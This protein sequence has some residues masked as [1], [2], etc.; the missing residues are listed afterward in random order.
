MFSFLFLHCKYSQIK[1]LNYIFIERKLVNRW[2]KN[3]I[4]SFCIIF[5]LVFLAAACGPGSKEPVPG[6]ADK[7]STE[8]PQGL[9][10]SYNGKDINVSLE[11]IMQLNEVTREITAVPKDDEEMKPRNVKGIL[12]EDV[13]QSYL[14]ISQ[15]DAGSIRLEAGDGYAIEVASDILKT[16][17]IIIAYEIDGKPLEDWEK[18]L[19]S[20]IPDVFEMYWV[21]NLI[22][23]EITDKREQNQVKRIIFLET[24]I[25]EVENID[26]AY[27]DENSKA[28]KISD[29][30]FNFSETEFQ[31]YVFIMST[32]GLEKIEKAEIFLDA[33]IK[34]TGQYAPMFLSE[35]LPKGMW[36]KD[37]LYFIY[38]S[39]V[40]FSE[41]SGFKVFDKVNTNGSQSIILKDVFRSCGI[42]ASE[43]YLFKSLDGYT[44]EIESGSID[45][46]FIYI[47]DNGLAAVYFEGLAKDAKVKDLIYIG[48]IE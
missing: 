44:A 18:P 12:L 40:Y 2:G 9:V 27:Y 1:C 26:Y 28:V 46:G 32:D 6:S 17:E 36:V 41:S 7:A 15:K 16:K 48:I 24:R 38:G 47:Q 4:L 42:S 11:Q 33:Y 39:S 29:L 3:L 30:L 43:K 23:I 8:S 19:R 37:I 13:F 10:L 35:S 14:G 25:S 5:T 21:K 22:R 31:N 34:Y 45:K 20:V